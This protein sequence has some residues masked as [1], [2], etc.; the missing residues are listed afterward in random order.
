MNESEK[1]WLEITFSLM[2]DKREKPLIISISNARK[3]IVWLEAAA[4]HP[5]HSHV[6]RRWERDI[7]K[8]IAAV[9]KPV[10]GYGMTGT[11]TRTV[12][13]SLLS[14]NTEITVPLT[15]SDHWIALCAAQLVVRYPT[16]PPHA[17]E[18]IEAIARLFQA[19]LIE[20]HP[21]IADLAER[22]WTEDVSK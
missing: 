12:E 1:H 19:G 20:D 11:R 16:L 22:G 13:V 6:A 5:G 14:N 15:V 4:R 21:D 3:V 10:A 17:R 7:A 18:W 9:G 2:S 8:R